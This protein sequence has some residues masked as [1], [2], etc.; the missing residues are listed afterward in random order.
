MKP[1]LS[2]FFNLF[3]L[4]IRAEERVP[5]KISTISCFSLL[6]CV[7]SKHFC[8][9]TIGP[10]HR[11]E[12]EGA[13]NFLSTIPKAQEGPLGSLK[14]FF[15]HHANEGRCSHTSLSPLTN[16]LSLRYILCP[17]SLFSCQRAFHLSL[18]PYRAA[19]KPSSTTE[20]RFDGWDNCYFHQ[21]FSKPADHKIYSWLGC[22]CNTRHQEN[23]ALTIG[24]GPH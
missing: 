5:R 4:E 16:C 8:A 12:P 7:P 9:S 17:P 24:C 19:T 15:H 10:S 21:F 23:T 13:P 22:L 14:E 18:V 2:F 3:S 1:S 6:Q 11:R 20:Q